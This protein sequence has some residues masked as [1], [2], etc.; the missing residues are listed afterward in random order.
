MY[1]YVDPGHRF[2][3]PTVLEC[4][5]CY[6]TVRGCPSTV[7]LF[8]SKRKYVQNSELAVLASHLIW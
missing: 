5:N 8:V 7:P 6:S 1:V 3:I 4:D 2:N